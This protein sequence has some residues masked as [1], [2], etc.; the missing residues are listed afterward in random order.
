MHDRMILKPPLGYGTQVFRMG[1]KVE[2][3]W[4]QHY[5][6]SHI[7]SIQ[8]ALHPQFTEHMWHQTRLRNRMRR[9][10][11]NWSSEFNQVGFPSRKD[12]CL[13][14]SK[15]WWSTRLVGEGPTEGCPI[16]SAIQRKMHSRK[17]DA[18]KWTQHSHWVLPM[19]FQSLALNLL[20]LFLVQVWN[21]SNIFFS[22]I[23]LKQQAPSHQIAYDN[24]SYRYGSEKFRIFP[25]ARNNW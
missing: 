22:H 14:W 25:G 3:F 18:V 4:N 10:Q 8:Q 16:N 17:G 20:T 21:F 11:A 2:C 9:L 6:C 19:R 12:L 24:L 13:C 15:I 5:E 23:N 7:L 1:K